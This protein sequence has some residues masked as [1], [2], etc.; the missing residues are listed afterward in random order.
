M[1]KSKIFNK[2]KGVIADVIGLEEGEVKPESHFIN[3]LGCDSILLSE[4]I[5]TIEDKFGFRI[6]DQ[7]AA[8]LRTVN[9]VVEYIHS[10]KIWQKFIIFI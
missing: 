4:L 10:I 2:L 1:E 7:D 5:M 8:K 9:D 6:T 3:D